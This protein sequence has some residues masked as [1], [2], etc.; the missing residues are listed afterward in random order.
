[1]LF[2]KTFQETSSHR[3]ERTSRTDSSCSHRFSQGHPAAIRGPGGIGPT[4]YLLIDAFYPRDDAETVAGTVL[5]GLA[6]KGKSLTKAKFDAIRQGA[7]G[8]CD[9]E[10]MVAALCTELGVRTTTY[11]THR[12][13]EREDKVEAQVEL[14]VVMRDT[15]VRN[16]SHGRMTSAT[17]FRDLAKILREELGPEHLSKP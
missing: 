2:K 7:P 1:M 16:F 14:L 12:N 11:L 5:A 13:P 4:G 17:G 3:S 6:S 15:G 8:S 9:D 10:S